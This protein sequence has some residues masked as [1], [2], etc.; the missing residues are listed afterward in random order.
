[1]IETRLASPSDVADVQTII[2]AAFATVREVY[3]PKPDATPTSENAG[4]KTETFVVSMDGEIKGSVCFYSQ[5]K[6]LQISQLAVVPEFRKRGVARAL[7]QAANQAAT[8]RG[9]TELRLNTIQETG[10]VAIFQRLGFTIHSTTKATWCISDRF[11]QLNDVLMTQ[12][13]SRRLGFA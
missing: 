13:C 3:R 12:R 11:E 8:K 10:N 5:A 9:A 2:D 1:M 6:A 4:L 7:L